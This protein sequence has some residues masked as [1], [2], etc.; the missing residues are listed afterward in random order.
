LVNY[1][2][3]DFVFGNLLSRNKKKEILIQIN[4]LRVN[5]YL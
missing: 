1:S 5:Y 2:Q 3:I 4:L